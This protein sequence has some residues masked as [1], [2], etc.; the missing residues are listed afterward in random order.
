MIN[1]PLFIYLHGFAS[2]PGGYK[3][4]FFV[5][6]LRARGVEPLVPDMN[7][8]RMSHQPSAAA[9][10]S[11][12]SS[13]CSPSNVPH[14]TSSTPPVAS[15]PSS[16]NLRHVSLPRDDVGETSGPG[17]FSSLTISGQVAEVQRL[18]GEHP[19]RQVV[20]LGSSL[21]A[22][23]AALVAARHPRVAA[24]VLMA[25][26]FHLAER[27]AARLGPE[28][29]A[30]WEADGAMDT[31]HFATGQMTPIGWGL[32]A[33][34]RSHPPAPEVTVPTLIMHGTDDEV[35]DPQGSVDYAARRPNVTLHLLPA[36][37]GLG[38]VVTTMVELAVDFLK[39]WFP[40][41]GR[42]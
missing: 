34:A 9:L 30:R 40:E 5:D 24:L 39:P 35:V 15:C 21:G 2:S 28:A 10:K 36:D 14:R 17:N 26:A 20:L 16:P 38:E 27:W 12:A 32:M 4:A 41:P 13:G 11:T 33:D 19:D 37:H 7:L 1:D 6:A 23:V 18:C 31:M 22:Y 29:M 3:V 42:A 8:A 25:P